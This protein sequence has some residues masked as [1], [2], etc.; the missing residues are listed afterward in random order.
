MDHKINWIINQICSDWCNYVNLIKHRIKQDVIVYS[1]ISSYGQP[2]YE[3]SKLK[4]NIKFNSKIN[5]IPK[6]QLPVQY[7]Q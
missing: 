4:L 2:I 7:Q 6:R 3:E 1:Y 5:W